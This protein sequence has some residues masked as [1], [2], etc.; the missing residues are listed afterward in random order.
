MQVVTDGDGGGSR[1][2]GDGLDDDAGHQEVQVGDACWQGFADGAAEDRSEQYQE[3]DRLEESAEQLVAVA[4]DV[5][6]A[7]LDHNPGVTDVG[8]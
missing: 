3:H 8:D 5:G 2:E 1:A 6:A 7:A 4:Q